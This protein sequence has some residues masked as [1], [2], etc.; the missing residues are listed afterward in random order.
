M[1]LFARLAIAT[2]LLSPLFLGGCSIINR[3]I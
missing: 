1:T 2:A 3:L